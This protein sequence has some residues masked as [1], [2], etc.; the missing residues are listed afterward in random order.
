MSG[1]LGHLLRSLFPL[2]KR[3]PEETRV[4]TAHGSGTVGLIEV[5]L[6]RELFR[7]S[8]CEPKVVYRGHSGKSSATTQP[9]WITHLDKSIQEDVAQFQ[10]T[11]QTSSPP[12]Q[13]PGSAPSTFTQEHPFLCW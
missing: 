4:Y 7:N 2:L 1:L 13:I 11:N 3:T 8:A 12:T 6:S 5:D 9:M 10:Q